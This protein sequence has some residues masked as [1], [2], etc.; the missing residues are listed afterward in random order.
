[1][2]GACFTGGGSGVEWGGVAMAGP[3]AKGWAGTVTFLLS[4][5]TLVAMVPEPSQWSMQ[6]GGRR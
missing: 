6:Q 3:T 2:S 1:M 5:E 4:L